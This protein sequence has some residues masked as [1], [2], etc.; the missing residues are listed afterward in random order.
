MFN[1]KTVFKP[2]RRVLRRHEIERMLNEEDVVSLRC[3][4]PLEIG[5][6][7]RVSGVVTV[8]AEQSEGSIRDCS[9]ITTLRIMVVT[10]EAECDLCRCLYEENEDLVIGTT[11]QIVF[12]NMSRVFENDTRVRVMLFE[13]VD[14]NLRAFEFVRMLV[15]E[16]NDEERVGRCRYDFV[17]FDDVRFERVVMTDVS[18]LSSDCGHPDAQ[19]V[20]FPFEFADSS[21]VHPRSDTRF[22]V[23]RQENPPHPLYALRYPVKNLCP[24]DSFFTSYE[25]LKNTPSYKFLRLPVRSMFYSFAAN[26]NIQCITS[27]CFFLPI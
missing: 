12:E 9:A 27:P 20:Y 2:R 16:N 17:V 19:R 26:D 6:I 22:P 7:V 4:Q 8:I 11:H 15:S 18:W 23:R 3:R 14:H 25:T 1:K 5:R 21:H 10:E 13:P 24:S